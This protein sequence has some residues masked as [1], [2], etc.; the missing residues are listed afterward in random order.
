MNSNSGNRTNSSCNDNISD[1]D[2]EG[3]WITTNSDSDSEQENLI[4][5][6]DGNL[7]RVSIPADDEEFEEDSNDSSYELEEDSEDNSEANSEA[8]SEYSYENNSQNDNIYETVKPYSV[9]YSY[10]KTNKTEKIEDCGICLDDSGEL[11]ETGCKHI[12][13]L[14]CLEQWFTHNEICPTCR[15]E[16]TYNKQFIEN[17]IENFFEQEDYNMIES[18]KVIREKIWYNCDICDNKIEENNK[19]YHK[20][21]NNYDLC[22]EC[23]LKQKDNIN[24]DEYSIYE[25]NY[26]IMSQNKIP[27]NIKQL[28]LVGEFEFNELNL[29]SLNK[30]ILNESK[31]SN[32]KFE[33]D[34]I[35]FEYLNISNSIITGFSDIRIENT[36]SDVSTFNNILKNTSEK[37]INFNIEVNIKDKDVTQIVFN[38]DNNSTLLNKL[39]IYNSLVVLSLTPD[40]IIFTNSDLNLVNSKIREIIL[41]NVVFNQIIAFPETLEK[42]NVRRLSIKNNNTIDLLGCNKLSDIIIKK[43]PITNIKLCKNIERKEFTL[44]Y[45]LTI[46]ECGIEKIDY[47]P[48]IF[49]CIDLSS[50][51]LTDGS[52]ELNKTNKYTYI[53]LSSNKIRSFKNIPK[54]IKSLWLNNNLLESVDLTDYKIKEISLSYNRINNFIIGDKVL[55]LI[56]NS[57]YL[58][59]ITINKEL[60]NLNVSRNKLE[61]II[62]KEGVERISTF[63]CS[64]NKLKQLNLNNTSINYFNCAYNKISSLENYKNVKSIIKINNNL[65]TNFTLYSDFY[66]KLNISR[67]LIKKIDISD[68]INENIKINTFKFLHKNIKNKILCFKKKY[69]DSFLNKNKNYIIINENKVDCTFLNNN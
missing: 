12:F 52:F 63:D 38:P 26:I 3:S 15:K 35:E 51:K 44:E 27:K 43:T 57:N 25:T 20:N 10:S 58:K 42:L 50:N 60:W 68:N 45:I 21:G 31:V 28:D 47:I 13:H 19:R 39:D 49:D 29:E 61:S 14:H 65:I 11:I 9:V 36:I 40:K 62:I 46:T 64:Y 1:I 69:S 54:N 24:T 59:S 34:K 55:E 2:S 4:A 7:V 53:N 17:E 32:V 5:V 16:F 33:S 66:S 6:I 37:I 48:D 41:N 22:E 67:T 23:Y 8:N 30:L 18:L 56:I